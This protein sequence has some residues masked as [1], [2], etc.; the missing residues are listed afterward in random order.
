MLLDT[1]SGYLLTPNMKQLKFKVAILL[2]YALL[3]KTINAQNQID[4]YGTLEFGS[5]EVGIKHFVYTDLKREN[6]G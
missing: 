6:P 2:F 4:L 5:H 3:I 1:T